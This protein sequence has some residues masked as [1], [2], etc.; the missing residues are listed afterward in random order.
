MLCKYYKLLM[1]CGTFLTMDGKDK[2]ESELFGSDFDLV[3][4]G[5]S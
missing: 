5:I 1:D 3:V 2:K 4:W